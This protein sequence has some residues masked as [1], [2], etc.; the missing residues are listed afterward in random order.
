MKSA[1]FRRFFATAWPVLEQ[2]TNGK[3]EQSENAL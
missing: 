3:V 1:E 2:S